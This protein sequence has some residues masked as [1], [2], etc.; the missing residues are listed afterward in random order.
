M[1]L[2]DQIGWD[3]HRVTYTE[4]QLRSLSELKKI[5]G[6]KI[7]SVFEIASETPELSDWTPANLVRLIEDCDKILERIKNKDFDSFVYVNEGGDK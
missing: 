7:S 2:N 1:N 4:E 5:N 3:T 6:G